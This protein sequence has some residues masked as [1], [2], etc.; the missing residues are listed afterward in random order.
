MIPLYR[1]LSVTTRIFS[2]PVANQITKSL[3]SNPKYFPYTKRILVGLGQQY[4]SLNR[5]IHHLSFKKTSNLLYKPLTE[6]RAIDIGSELV[7]ELIAYG[8]LLC[9]GIYEII[10]LQRESKEI[11]KVFDE[12]ISSVNNKL[13]GL[14]DQYKV[15]YFI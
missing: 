8:S 5:K 14:E 10:K 13:E 1:L 6:D 3:K 15:Y 11:D 2:I 7:G 9:V 12:G 4:Y